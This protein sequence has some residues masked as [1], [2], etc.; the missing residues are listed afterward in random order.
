L[1]FGG[2][3]AAESWRLAVEEFPDGCAFESIGPESGFTAAYA[4]R[5]IGEIVVAEVRGQPLTLCARGDQCGPQIVLQAIAEGAAT[6]H[7]PDEGALALKAGQILVSRA[8][9]GAVLAAERG[10]RVVS[11]FLAPHLLAPRFATADEL[12][13]TMVIGG[14]GSAT[15]LLHGLIVGLAGTHPAAGRGGAVEALGGLLAMELAQRPRPPTPL[16]ELATRRAADLVNYLRRNFANPSLSPLMMADDLGISVRYAHKLMVLVGRSF[17]QELTAQ[18][19]QAARAAF[20]ANLQPRQTIADIAISV[21][22]NDLSQFN[23]HF[24]AAFGMT[25]RAARKLDESCGY[26]GEAARGSAEPALRGAALAGAR[27]R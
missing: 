18:R 8:A 6:Y 17:R 10:A 24:R 26:P 1:R 4:E 3:T 13:R 11:V 22:F 9:P 15:P 21:G 2:R 20:A 14:A 7:A 5:R 16:S 23:R 27:A 19:L 25:P 12:A